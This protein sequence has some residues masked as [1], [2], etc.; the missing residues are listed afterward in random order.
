MVYTVSAWDDF[1]ID[2]KIR[3]LLNIFLLLLIY[4]Y[5]HLFD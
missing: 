3:I 4:Y 1:Y 2:L 5:L